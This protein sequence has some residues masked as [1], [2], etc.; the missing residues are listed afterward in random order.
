MARRETK[1]EAQSDIDFLATLHDKYYDSLMRY[2]FVRIH[3]ITEAEDIASETFLKALQSLKSF[4][5]NR[6]QMKAWLFKIAHNITIDHI[7]KEN[8]WREA[9]LNITITS[10]TPDIETIAENKDLRR[11]VIE[12]LKH[13]TP[14]QQEVLGLRVFAGLKSAEAGTILGKSPGAVR[15]MQ[16]AAIESLRKLINEQ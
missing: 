9:Q 4:K 3:D 11:R 5:G 2:V 13:L 10:Q 15:E 16:R 14:S 7:R 6:E 12:C 8:R 1:E